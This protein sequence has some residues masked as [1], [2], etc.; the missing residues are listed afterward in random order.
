MRHAHPLFTC[1]LATCTAAVLPN[2]AH[3]QATPSS[4]SDPAAAAVALQHQPLRASGGIEMG[5]TDWPSA[6]V[7]VAA[8]PRGQADILAWE[9]EQARSAPAQGL[10]PAAAHEAA[11]AVPHGM[12]QHPT[13]PRPGGQL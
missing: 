6:H 3:A 12:H 4:A 1:I 13:A 10:A 7:S 8:F 2:W 9:A 11:H 5:E